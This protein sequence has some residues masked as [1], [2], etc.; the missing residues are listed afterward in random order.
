MSK[1]DIQTASLS[2]PLTIGV[3]GG[4]GPQ[5]TVDFMHEIIA[6][7]P[8]SKDQEH[9]R[10]LVDSNPQAPDRQAALK[11]DASALRR[12]LR[13]MALGLEA[14]GADFL[15]LPC[16][17]AHAFTDEAVAAVQVPWVSIIEVTVEATEQAFAE[18]ATS[19]RRVGLLAT[20]ACIIANLYQ[21]AAKNA[22]VDMRIPDPAAQAECMALIA[23]V[24]GGDLSGDARQNMCQ[25]ARAFVEKEA[26][27][28]LIA[29]CTEIPLVLENDDTA[30]VLISSTDALAAR[31]VDLALGRLPL[32]ETC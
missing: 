16:N 32:P 20:D 12:V 14:R 31:S 19:G 23:Q 25:L 28:V 21:R 5:A 18:R 27:D 13:E 24:K 26:L 7:T 2:S 22:D 8:A 17:T 29:G 3:L 4:M 11:G 9:I 6:R 15:V 1:T 10:L 30:A